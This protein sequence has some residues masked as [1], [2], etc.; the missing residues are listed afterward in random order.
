MERSDSLRTKKRDD[1]FLINHVLMDAYRD[2][3]YPNDNVER[4][5]ALFERTKRL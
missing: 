4:I 2:G 5:G 3:M 1:D